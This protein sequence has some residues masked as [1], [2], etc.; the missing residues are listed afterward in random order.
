[1]SHERL[2]EWV[3]T[4]AAANTHPM[5]QS[6]EGDVEQNDSDGERSEELPDDALEQD[7]ITDDGDESSTSSELTLG[8]QCELPNLASVVAE[9]STLC[10]PISRYSSPLSGYLF[11]EWAHDRRCSCVESAKSRLGAEERFYLF[12]MATLSTKCTRTTFDALQHVLRV[13]G[14]DNPFRSL[15]RVNRAL[16][17]AVPLVTKVYDMCQNGCRLYA[18]VYEPWE[19]N[20][21]C[22][23]CGTSRRKGVRALLGDPGS[24]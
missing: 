24:C 4:E 12:V 18:G 6:M 10:T 7:D 21:A 17:R 11:T 13:P 23:I 1:M 22:G 15:D 14:S 8:G 5:G 19:T 9:P 16:E 2:K 20:Q 3:N